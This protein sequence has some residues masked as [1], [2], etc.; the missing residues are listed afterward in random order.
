MN[1]AHPTCRLG[2]RRGAPSHHASEKACLQLATARRLHPAHPRTCACAQV[3]SFAI[4][5]IFLSIALKDT[6]F[7]AGLIAGVALMAIEIVW[8]FLAYLKGHR[9]VRSAGACRA[10]CAGDP[11]TA[12]LPAFD[13]DS[14]IIWYAALAL[15]VMQPTTPRP[16]V[17]PTL[18][19]PWLLAFFIA[20]LV[21]SY[22]SYFD[23]HHWFILMLFGWLALLALISLVIRC[24]LAATAAGRAGCC[25]TD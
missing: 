3:L 11:C 16:Q 13:T 7:R 6:G 19:S 4:P 23:V 8:G 25:W 17:W 15:P 14:A 24:A 2:W 21:G 20:V 12:R 1:D 5:A 18:L 10:C 22:F 9:R